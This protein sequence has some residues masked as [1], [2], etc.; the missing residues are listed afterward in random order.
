M[1]EVLE[2][3]RALNR[4]VMIQSSEGGSSFFAGKSLPNDKKG[5]AD[6]DF[7]CGGWSALPPCGGACLRNSSFCSFGSLRQEVAA[8]VRQHVGGR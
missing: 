6:V 8:L 7:G 1:N 4:P 2:V 3:S 5:S